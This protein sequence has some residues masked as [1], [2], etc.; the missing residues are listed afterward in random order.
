MEETTSYTTT[1]ITFLKG[2]IGRFIRLI[3]LLINML[4]YDHEV[5]SLESDNMS[6]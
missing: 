6:S 1:K 2:P 3:P 5:M 4:L